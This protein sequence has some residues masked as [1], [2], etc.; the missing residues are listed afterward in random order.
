MID[1]L[2][3]T[4]ECT[5]L[6]YWNFS[7]FCMLRGSNAFVYQL[8]YYVVCNCGCVE[9]YSKG[10]PFALASAGIRQGVSCGLLAGTSVSNRAVTHMAG[11][12]TQ[13]AG[14]ALWCMLLVTVCYAVHVRS[15]VTQQSVI[16]RTRGD[17]GSGESVALRQIRDYNKPWGLPLRLLNAV[18]A[19]LDT[20]STTWWECKAAGKQRANIFS[21]YCPALTAPNTFHGTGRV[22]YAT[23]DLATAPS[24]HTSPRACV[25]AMT[26][27]L[28]VPA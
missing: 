15:P 19:V 21:T 22:A 28:Q 16:L 5:E 8:V 26:T 3:T 2:A 1:Q 6:D 14:R 11:A 25:P 23:W 18:T 4:L 7:L 12:V 24:V 17:P 10:T 20:L 27:R 9:D 13:M